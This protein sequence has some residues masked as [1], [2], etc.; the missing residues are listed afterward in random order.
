VSRHWGGILSAVAGAESTQPL[1]SGNPVKLSCFPNQLTPEGKGI[2]PSLRLT[3]VRLRS[4][5]SVSGSG[6]RHLRFGWNHGV[7][8]LRLIN[9]RQCPNRRAGLRR[10]GGP[11]PDTVGSFKASTSG[12]S[13]AGCLRCPPGVV[14]V[15]R[16]SPHLPK[17]GPVPSVRRTGW[18]AVG[19]P[20]TV[21]RLNSSRVDGS[22]PRLSSRISRFASRCTQLPSPCGGFGKRTR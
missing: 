4:G 19:G 16:L 20:A 2:Q 14:S 22:S 7:K 10:L 9:P 11:C 12:P 17:T 8:G 13:Q 18:K 3:F 21:W 15:G 6:L 1:G 5:P